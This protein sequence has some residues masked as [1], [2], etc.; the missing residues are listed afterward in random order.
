MSRKPSKPTSQTKADNI[1]KLLQR[2]TG[3]SVAELAKASGW[4]RHR[5]HGFLLGTLKK[6]R[7]LEFNSRKEDKKDRRYFVEG[8]A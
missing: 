8:N 3:A 5:V 4:Q 2:N 7:S 6:K 1:L